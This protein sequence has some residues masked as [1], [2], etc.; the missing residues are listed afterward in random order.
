MIPRLWI[1]SIVLIYNTNFIWGGDVSRAFQIGQINVWCGS[2]ILTSWH[3]I[4]SAISTVK[5]ETACRNNLRLGPSRSITIQLKSSCSPYQWQ[6]GMPAKR[7]EK[8][9]RLNIMS[10]IYIV[11]MLD[12]AWL[13]LRPPTRA[14]YIILSCLSW[15]CLID[16]GSRLMAYERLVSMSRAIAAF[17]INVMQKRW[18]FFEVGFGLV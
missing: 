12:T 10:V 5:S 18:G 11:S 9:K 2:L 13:Y 8:R 1:C 16:L 17:T 4:F 3:A 14:S 15:G 6:A 7:E